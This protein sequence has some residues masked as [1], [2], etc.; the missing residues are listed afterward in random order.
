MI[1]GMEHS[2]RFSGRRNH[3]NNTIDSFEMSAF[4]MPFDTMP[5]IA[6]GSWTTRP[7]DESSPSS[8]VHEQ[9]IPFGNDN[10]KSKEQEQKAKTGEVH[11]IPP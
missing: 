5:S 9:Q 4:I 2:P 3:P 8:P 6:V 10:K 1:V 7:F 11:G